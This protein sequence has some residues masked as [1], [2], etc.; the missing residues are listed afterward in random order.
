M[1]SL[2]FIPLL[3]RKNSNFIPEIYPC[4]F[5]FHFFFFNLKE[6]QNTNMERTQTVKQHQGAGTGRKRWKQKKDSENKP[7]QRAFQNIL[8]QQGVN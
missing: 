6:N 4:Y 2:D 3:A 5:N 8:I 1:W 7:T